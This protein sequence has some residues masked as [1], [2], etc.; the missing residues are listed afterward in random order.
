VVS[1]F[2]KQIESFGQEIIA[3]PFAPRK[4]KSPD[5]HLP[6]TNTP[7]NKMHHIAFYG[8]ASF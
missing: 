7:K 8:A 2:I 6:L 1:F 4:T 3:G 5:R